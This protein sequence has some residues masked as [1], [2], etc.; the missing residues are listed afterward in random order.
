MSARDEGDDGRRELAQ[1]RTVLRALCILAVLALARPAA[2]RAKG[3]PACV[4]S[5]GTVI[6]GVTSPAACKK[7][8]A[9]WAK[10]GTKSLPKD[11]AAPRG[12]KRHGTKHYAHR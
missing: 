1:N 6:E 3:G 8:G 9:R 10:P 2:A 4:D 7:L 12:S 5:F 11:A